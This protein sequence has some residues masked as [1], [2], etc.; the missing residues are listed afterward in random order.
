MLLIISRKAV[1]KPQK[2]VKIIAMGKTSKEVATHGIGN[3]ILNP[4]RGSTFLKSRLKP[5][6]GDIEP[7]SGFDFFSHFPWVATSSRSYPWLI[8]SRHFVA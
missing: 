2:G 5:I 4:E 8:T 6:V 1:E 7:P 3:K